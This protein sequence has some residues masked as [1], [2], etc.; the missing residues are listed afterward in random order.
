MQRTTS[1]KPFWYRELCDYL[2]KLG[3]GALGWRA[4]KIAFCVLTGKRMGTKPAVIAAYQL[5][6]AGKLKPDMVAFRTFIG[7]GAIP[8]PS[9]VKTLHQSK[10]VSQTARN[11]FYRSF[12]W[13]KL[14][15]ATL[16]RYGRRCM[17][18]GSMD[19]PFHVDH[20][21]PIRKYW[22]LRLDPENTQVLCD[23]CNYGKGSWDETDFREK[24]EGNVIPFPNVEGK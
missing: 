7:N 8:V 17:C 2:F 13:K 24:H 21:K 5:I 20:I 15:Y 11:R 16:L 22:N 4:I 10:A 19:G 12:E 18:C 23:G 1:G 3:Y 14:R 6:R 9:A